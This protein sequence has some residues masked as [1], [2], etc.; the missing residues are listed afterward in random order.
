MKRT[1]PAATPSRDCRTIQVR[2]PRRCFAGCAAAITAGAACSH[3]ES[4]LCAALLLTP[5]STQH[6]LQPNPQEANATVSTGE[7]GCCACSFARCVPF[8]CCRYLL[9]PVCAPLTL[10]VH[11]AHSPVHLPLLCAARRAPGRHAV[12]VLLQHRQR[13]LPDLGQR[14]AH[15]AWLAAAQLCGR[16]PGGRQPQRHALD[17]RRVR[18]RRR[19]ALPGEGWQLAAPAPL[20]IAGTGSGERVSAQQRP[21]LTRR[22]AAP[23]PAACTA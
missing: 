5:P 11:N 19:G 15:P 17:R 21:L 12:L 6:P 13:A 3:P 23:T 10:H 16:R 18:R 14:A 7:G 20:A 2:A 22:P 4:S 9:L 1:G 8:C